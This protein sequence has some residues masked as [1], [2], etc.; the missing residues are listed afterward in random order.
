M[1]KLRWYD[2]REGRFAY[3][4][5]NWVDLSSTELEYCVSVDDEH[6]HWVHISK[7]LYLLESDEA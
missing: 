3:A 7:G 6:G 2:W 5:A 4:P 1:S